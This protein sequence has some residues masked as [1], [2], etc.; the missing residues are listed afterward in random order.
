MNIEQLDA[1]LSR[2]GRN[3]YNPGWTRWVESHRIG[4]EKSFEA[5]RDSAWRRLVK[6]KRGVP[7]A[8]SFTRDAPVSVRI[9]TKDEFDAAVLLPDACAEW[10]VT[11]FGLWTIGWANCISCQANDSAGLLTILIEDVRAVNLVI[12]PYR[13]TPENQGAIPGTPNYRAEMPLNGLCK[14][15]LAARCRCGRRLSL[16]RVQL[17]RLRS[18]VPAGACEVCLG[19]SLVGVLPDKPTRPDLVKLSRA[20]IRVYGE[21][22]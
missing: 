11:T 22:K 20:S 13:D 14:T 5:L 8:L 21:T 18:L 2:L 19:A 12:R 4:A 1:E 15:C 16:N 7:F 3:G 6:R 10:E 9:T 17:R